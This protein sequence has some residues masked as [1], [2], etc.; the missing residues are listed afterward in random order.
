MWG[1]PHGSRS[2]VT[3]RLSPA[4]ASRPEVWARAASALRRWMEAH[5][6]GR[7]V[8]TKTARRRKD[9][10]KAPGS[11]ASET[12]LHPVRKTEHDQKAGRPGPGDRG[13]PVLL[14]PPERGGHPLLG[15]VA[16]PRWPDRRPQPDRRGRHLEG[17]R[18][19]GRPGLLALPR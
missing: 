12:L 10:L 19:L 14:L 11:L 7:S 6:D 2:T 1:M 4:T 8:S 15:R 17:P 18:L 16:L 9:R 5:P 3:G 13:R